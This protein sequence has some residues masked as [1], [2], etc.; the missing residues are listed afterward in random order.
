MQVAG[1]SWICS[2]VWTGRKND[3]QRFKGLEWK[4]ETSYLRNTEGATCLA[5]PEQVQMSGEELSLLS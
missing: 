2:C 3:K 5:A 4:I 1:G